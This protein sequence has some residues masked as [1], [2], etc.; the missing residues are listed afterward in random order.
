MRVLFDVTCP[1]CKRKFKY[2]AEQR[3]GEAFI[4]CEPEEGGC[5]HH[6]IIRWDISFI[7]NLKTSDITWKESEIEGQ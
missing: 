6:F 4:D 3:R 7:I 2:A 1:S 5:E